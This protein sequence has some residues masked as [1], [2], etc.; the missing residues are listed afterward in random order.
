MEL[1]PAVPSSP[2]AGPYESAPCADPLYANTMARREY[3]ASWRVHPRLSKTLLILAGWSAQAQ[4]YG[5][6][7]KGGPVTDPNN[8]VARVAPRI[9]PSEAKQWTLRRAGVGWKTF[10]YQKQS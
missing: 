4:L 6:P 1:I 9:N 8:G 2:T 3:L 7:L 10:P 5:V